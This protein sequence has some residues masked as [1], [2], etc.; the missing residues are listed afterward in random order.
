MSG[1]DGDFGFDAIGDK[2]ADNNVSQLSTC[3]P[4]RTSVDQA[5]DLN[6]SCISQVPYVF[7]RGFVAMMGALTVPIIFGIM[8]ESGYPV[9]VAAF[10]ACLVLFGESIPLAQSQHELRSCQVRS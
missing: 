7:M 4:R 5:D 1:F 2:Y 10:S 6:V 3:G 9:I 8:R